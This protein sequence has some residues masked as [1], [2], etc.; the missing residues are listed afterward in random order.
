MARLLKIIV[1]YIALSAI[2]AVFIL[3]GLFPWHPIT[4]GGWGL[5]LVLALPLTIVGELIGEALWRNRLAQA[6]EKKTKERSLSGLRILYAL[7]V[8]LLLFSF[9]FAVA[10]FME[11]Q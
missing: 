5:L 11:Y 9:V 2:A 4:A 7:V 1:A 8:M 6:V 3:I 10:Q